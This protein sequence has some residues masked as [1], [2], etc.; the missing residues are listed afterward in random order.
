[1]S[2]KIETKLQKLSR[3][4]EH[5]SESQPSK[6]KKI[7]ENQGEPINLVGKKVEEETKINLSDDKDNQIIKLDSEAL[8]QISEN[9]ESNGV[10][11]QDPKYSIS[12]FKPC[13]F[14]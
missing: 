11:T 6:K 1:M 10:V 2:A 14:K 5:F 3:L 9:R 12:Y 7:T 4:Q 8:N 13:F